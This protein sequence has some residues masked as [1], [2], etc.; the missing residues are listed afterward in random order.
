M[1]RRDLF[2]MTDASEVCLSSVA[3][4]T[5][6]PDRRV[7]VTKGSQEKATTSSKQYVVYLTVHRHPLL[8]APSFEVD[9]ERLT[10]RDSCSNI[11]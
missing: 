6:G 5:R 2:L 7:G 10:T 1:D 8:L 4:D 9:L 3:F 11:Q